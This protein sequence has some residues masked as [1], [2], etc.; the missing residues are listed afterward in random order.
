MPPKVNKLFGFRKKVSDAACQTDSVELQTPKLKKAYS[1]KKKVKDV[2]CQTENP[3]LNKL[4]SSFKRKLLKD[5]ACQ[6]ETTEMQAPKFNRVFS[7]QRKTKDATCQTEAAELQ[8]PKLKQMFNLKRKV[9]EANCQTEHF[10]LQND[11]ESCTECPN[12]GFVSRFLSDYEPLRRLGQ[13]GFGIVLEA[14]DKLVDIPYAVK[15]IPLPGSEAEKERVMREVRSHARLSHQHIVRYYVTWL[16]APPPG[17]QARADIDLARK[18]GASI[19]DPGWT[20]STTSDYPSGTAAFLFDEFEDGNHSTSDILLSLEA[21]LPQLLPSVPS[22]VSTTQYQEKLSSQK[23]PPREYL[24]VAMELCSGGTLKDW[25]LDTPEREEAVSIKLFRQ[26][27]SGVDYIHKQGL[28]HRDLKPSNLYLSESGCI[29]IGDFGLVAHAGLSEN[30]EEKGQDDTKE[31]SQHVGTQLYMSPEQLDRE[32]Y[33]HKVDIYS[34]GIILVEL[35]VPFATGMERATVLTN[36]KQNL[37]PESI[38][39]SKRAMLN[40]MLHTQ[41]RERPE[42]REILQHNQKTSHKTRLDFY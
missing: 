1:F 33:N 26:I 39:Q 34:L 36:A 19:Q 16:E 24:Y 4:F 9:K 3:K 30:A 27:C 38:D 8:A 15:R 17:W 28:I 23:E 31:L 40:T 20:T 10:K 5:A 42:A 21:S 32:P 2:C 12:P 29:K 13:G 37:Y 7:L 11:L 14:R 41:P 35:L 6:T 18:T 25:L 22:T